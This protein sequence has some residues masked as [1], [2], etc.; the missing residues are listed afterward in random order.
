MRR[1]LS[2]TATDVICVLSKKALLPILVTGTPAMVDGIVILVSVPEYPVM[3]AV[4]SP[5]Y[6]VYVQSPSAA[7]LALSVMPG[8]NVS[9][10]AAVS[11]H[12]SVFLY[13]AHT[14]F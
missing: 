6:S 13:I 7:A 14:S 9:I 8:N 1:T 10:M 4:V 3:A 2:G 12:E 5:S 11:S